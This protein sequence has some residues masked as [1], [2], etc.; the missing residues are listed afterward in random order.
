[1]RARHGVLA[2]AR[3]HAGAKSSLAAA[4]AAAR[5]AVE[6]HAACARAPAA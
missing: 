3:R 2:D 4:A 6:H 5:R 1:M